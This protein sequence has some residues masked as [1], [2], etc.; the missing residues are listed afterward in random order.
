MDQE[1]NCSQDLNR[2]R[3]TPE[4]SFVVRDAEIQSQNNEIEAMKDELFL[5]PILI[6]IRQIHLI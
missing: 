2:V 5:L 3:N 6:Q 1:E 4:T